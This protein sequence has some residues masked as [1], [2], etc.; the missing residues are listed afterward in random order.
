MAGQVELHW[1]RF[2]AVLMW[3]CWASGTK[4]RRMDSETRGGR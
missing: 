1:A 4:R 3:F 2:E